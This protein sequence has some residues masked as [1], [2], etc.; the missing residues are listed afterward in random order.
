V[1]PSWASRLS[2][3]FRADVP[4]RQLLDAAASTLALTLWN[5]LPALAMTVLFAVFAGVLSAASNLVYVYLPE[6][7]PRLCGL[8][9]RPASAGQPH[10]SAFSTFLLPVMWRA[11]AFT[12]ALRRVLPARR[13]SCDLSAV[14]TGD[15]GLPLENLDQGG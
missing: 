1:A 9:D 7:F 6:L 11:T 4:D 5:P 10:R 2:T 8:R 3:A 14:G 15:T 12:A 13:R